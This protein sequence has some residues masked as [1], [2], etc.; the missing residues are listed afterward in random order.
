MPGGIAAA[1]SGRGL[2][3]GQVAEG[4]RVYYLAQRPLASWPHQVGIIPRQADWFQHRPA[5]DALTEA[6]ANGGIAVLCQVLAGTGGVGKTQLA[7]NYARHTRHELDLVVWV[8]ATSR[9]SI[10][11]AYA[12]A[13]VE[14]LGSDPAT[15]EQAAA[16]FLAW[17]EPKASSADAPLGDVVRWLVVLDDLVDTADLR[18]LWPPSSIRGRTLVTTR[19]RDTNL[20]GHGR[21]RID[22]GLFT[23]GEASAYL[24]AALGAHK[25]QE[26]A[27]E[28]AALAEDLGYLPLA[29]SQAAA[30]LIETELDCA[31]YR[32]LLADQV[33]K[34]ADLL[35]EPGMLPDDQSATLAAAWSLSIDRADH[36]RPVGLAR[37]MLQLAAMLDPSGI[38]AAILTSAAAL[39]YLAKQRIPRNGTS[40]ADASAT[41]PAP[42]TADGAVDAL[43]ALYRLN[44]ID[45]SPATPDQA[46]RIHQLIQRAVRESLSADLSEETAHA[47]ADALASVWP[48]IERD[49]THSQA[50]RAN[51]DV[52]RRVAEKSL[53]RPRAHPVLFRS[54]NSL[55][56]SGQV[57]S[58]AVHFER[59][60]S[61]AQ[62]HLGLDHPDVLAA[63]HDLAE[64]RGQTGNVAGAVADC[65]QLLA[66]RERVLGADHPDTMATR[67]NLAV[68]RAM[69]GDAAGAVAAFKALLA[70]RKRVL[71]PDHPD[72]LTTRHGLA[73][74][75]GEA[76]DVAGAIADYQQLLADRER[77]L[78]ADHP[79]TLATRHGLA[80]WQGQVGD[81]VGAVAAFQELVSQMLRVLGPDYPDT[82]NARHVLIDWRREAGEQA[83]VA[84][85]EQLLADRERVLGADH[86]ETLATRRS[87]A[88]WR[89]DQGD[90]VGA[91]AACRQL[92][93][94]QERVLGADHPDTLATRQSIASYRGEAGDVAGAIGDYEQLLAD[95]ERVLGADHP[96]TLATRQS[97]AYWRGEAGDVAGAIGDYEQLLADRERVLGADHPDTLAT[98]RSIAYWRGEQGD[99]V[100]ALADYRQL[101]ADQ[102][103]VLGADHPDTLATRQSI[104]YYRSEAGDVAGA[105]ADYEQ[106]LADEERVLGTDSADILDI[107]YNLAYRR[108]E[109]G[110]LVGAL[111][112]YRQLLAH[113]E[114]VLGLGHRDTVITRRSIAYWRGQADDLDG[115][116]TDYRQALELTDAEADPRFY[117]VVLHDI[118]GVLRAQGELEE[119][120][121]L[122]QQAADH[123]QRGDA[124]PDDIVVTVLSLAQVQQSWAGPVRRCGPGLRRWRSC[125]L[126]R[127]RSL[128]RWLR[129]WSSWRASS[130]KPTPG[131]LFRCWRRLASCSRWRGWASP[132]SAWRCW[133]CW[134]GLTGPWAKTTGPRRRRRRRTAFLPAPRTSWPVR[135]WLLCWVWA[136]S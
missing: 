117:G 81:K 136:R 39:A 111:A 132:P 53:W 102:E 86:P 119:A 50:L 84:D 36:V 59:L 131:R 40:A 13:G 115:A 5:V 90:V 17:L 22:V 75:R 27:S 107:R 130:F 8:N 58:A 43:R 25:R 79:D 4:G 42:V 62:Q 123:K 23:E 116:L 89:G 68:W 69:A 80:F 128:V 70:D 127:D 88:Y 28:I 106:L 67:N 83:I 55:G 109:S 120:V 33:H 31:A 15:P 32:A 38:P 63:R 97:I 82:L 7:A 18:G 91:L 112:D 105:I 100:G 121:R 37:P 98:R 92:L 52:L 26:P 71:G 85:Y 61:S 114:R 124:D 30:Y 2:A 29:I 16:A 45:Y 65:Q 108:A 46:V 129:R 125:G 96:D 34:L 11:A 1:A 99:V 10:T 95:R 126:R 73:R 77:V 103:R 3:I 49:A 21:Q 57:T 93:A 60:A 14:I 110:D 101:L 122:Y 20:T 44:L 12:Q 24:A 66:D 54:G 133:T 118:A 51:A 64:W 87:I 74:W 134:P 9:E 56:K 35:P 41:D 76:G 47:A 48:D 6:V 113:Q 135:M 78:G 94:D 104:A 19:R 72:T